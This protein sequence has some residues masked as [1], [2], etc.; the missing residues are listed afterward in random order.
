MKILVIYEPGAFGQ[1]L[2]ERLNQ[3]GLNITPLL[4]SRPAEL[5]LDQ[6]QSW[7]EPDF[8]LVVNAITMDDPELAE[9]QPEESRVRL[10]DI[11]TALAQRA[12]FH[13]V[14]MLQLSS[15]YVFDGRKQQ[16]YIASNPG[17]PLSIL[18][19]CQWD[20]EQFL[21]SNLP[22]HLILRTGWSLERFVEKV[23][24]YPGSDPMHMS[25]RHF[26]Q[27]TDVSDRVRVVVAI[28]QQLS[29]GAEAWG[30]Y[31]YAGADPV[32]LYKLGLEIAATLPSGK[33]PHLI[34]EEAPWLRLEPTNAILNCKKIRHTFGIQQRSW[35]DS[36]VADPEA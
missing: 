7:L 13:A 31:Q 8:D 30:T 1:S 3:T 12:A 20:T 2:L 32:S 15:C 18:G 10:Y 34:E 17:N 29:C 27:P 28:M 6:L 19:Q 16:P 9:Q 23:T 24:T 35:R 4:L 25:G 26:G 33:Q 11:P 5:A 22:R 14:A 36:L 21:R